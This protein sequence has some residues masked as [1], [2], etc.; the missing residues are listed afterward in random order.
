M[1]TP[2][3]STPFPAPSEGAE[4]GRESGA[5]SLL[6]PT[7]PGVCAQAP[8]HPQAVT[9]CPQGTHPLP[10]P[11][12]L[13]HT[14]CPAGLL[15]THMGSAKAAQPG[16]LPGGL[17]GAD[18]VL[19]ARFLVSQELRP[20][21]VSVPSLFCADKVCGAPLPQARCLAVGG[22]HAPR[23]P[24]VTAIHADTPHLP[25]RAQPQSLLFC[26]ATRTLSCLGQT[27]PLRVLGLSSCGSSSDSSKPHKT[28]IGVCLSLL[29]E[30]MKAGSGPG[31]SCSV[32]SVQHRVWH[33]VGAQ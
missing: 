5:E 23:K 29:A 16:I 14:P 22:D 27:S 2:G 8:R 1:C 21:G 9:L 19:L 18:P 11:P 17:R 26:K 15:L 33:L 6:K 10:P 24:E 32:P 12:H 31:S 20:S 4:G 28:H 30:L 13:H 3:F 25:F 7:Q